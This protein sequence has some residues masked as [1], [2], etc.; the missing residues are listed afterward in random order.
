MMASTTNTR[1]E[2]KNIERVPPQNLEAERAVLGGVL[3]EPEAATMAIEI[4]APENFYR[5]AHGKIFSA[6]TTLFTKHEPIDVMTFDDGG[7]ITSMK[8]YWSFD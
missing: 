5:P 4:V 8:A 2:L 7:K 3:L 1:F 6:M